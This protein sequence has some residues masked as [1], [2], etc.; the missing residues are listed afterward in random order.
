[1]KAL[2]AFNLPLRELENAV[3]FR[4]E[5]EFEPH[6]VITARGE[7]ISRVNVWGI[8]TRTFES[9]NNFASISIDD[10]S[11]TID[12]NAFNEGIPLL[13]KVRE[14]NSVKVIGKMRENNNGIYILAEGVQKISFA[15]EML[16]RLQNIEAF[17]LKPKKERKK[18]KKQ[19]NKSELD[20]FTQAS[21]LTIKREVIE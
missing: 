17:T 6:Y 21:E 10:F 1:M 9:E 5:G 18:P 19:S 20:E 7:R 14:G 16:K 15:E 13:K 8:V 11:G 3:F 12:V 2:K 4:G